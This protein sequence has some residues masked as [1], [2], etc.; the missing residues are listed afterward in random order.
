MPLIAIRTTVELADSNRVPLL[1]ECSK[2]VAQHTGKPEAYV[3]T[4][5]ERVS[6]MTMGGTAAPA[7]FVEVRGVG[8]FS[9]KQT[10]S[11]SQAVCELLA[12]RLGVSSRRIYLNFTGFDGSMWGFD[13]STFG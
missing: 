1:Q 13:G 9:G 7:C 11:L 3:M 5:L 10:A 2:L 6:A 4:L 12:E 8:A